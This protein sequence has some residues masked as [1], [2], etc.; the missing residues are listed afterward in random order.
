MV[1]VKIVTDQDIIHHAENAAEMYKEKQE[2][3]IEQLNLLEKKLDGDEVGTEES[4]IGYYADVDA[5]GSVDGIIYA[6][7]AVGGEGQFVNSNGIYS[8]T[9]ETEGLKSYEICNENGTGFGDWTSPV[10]SA[11]EGSGT[12]DRFYV[13]KLE[14]VSSRLL[15]WYYAASEEG[16]KLEDFVDGTTNDFGQGKINTENMIAKWESGMYGEQNLSGAYNDIWGEIKNEVNQGWF[17]PSK[18]ELAAYS[19][20]VFK[21]AELGVSK[22]DISG[23]YYSS[24]VCTRDSIWIADYYYGRISSLS[25]NGLASTRLST[26]F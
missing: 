12:K 4:Y 7:L 23:G 25:L 17:V 21:L 13:M 11:I 14:D 19:D 18:S 16:G 22:I 5:N 8:Y 24:S 3:E 26:K 9:A 20:M 1:S 15:F 6:D 2:N 10:L